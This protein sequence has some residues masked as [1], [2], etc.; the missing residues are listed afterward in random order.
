MSLTIAQCRV[1]ERMQAGAVI[2]EWCRGSKRSYSLLW[3]EDRPRWERTERHLLS[4]TVFAL[5]AAGLIRQDDS[6]G[7]RML[8][9]S[10][11]GWLVLT[12]KGRAL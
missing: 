11:D 6:I 9:F 2:G 1:I 4:Q 3:T 10:R 7:E 5:L 12:E 8:R